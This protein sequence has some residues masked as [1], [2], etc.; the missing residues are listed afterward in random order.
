MDAA[1]PASVTLAPWWGGLSA[2][3]S[4]E[5]VT[6]QVDQSLGWLPDMASTQP[7]CPPPRWKPHVLLEGS[8]SA[9][10]STAEEPSCPSAPSLD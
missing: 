1:R 2:E 4:Q 5:K 8:R 9:P 6:L 10:A 7:P 3:H